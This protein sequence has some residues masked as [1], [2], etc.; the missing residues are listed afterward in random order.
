M[1]KKATEGDLPQPLVSLLD[2]IVDRELA[3]RLTEVMEAAGRCVLRLASI[4]LRELE[5]KDAD[6]GAADLTLWEKVAPAVGETVV[7]V[8]E[9]CA[10]IDAAFPPTRSRASLFGEE[11]SDQRAEYEAA[12]VFRAIS[13]LLKKELAD[14]SSLVRRPEMLSSPWG[15]LAELQRLRNGLRARVN[16]AVYLSA[17]AL[18]ACTRDEVVPGYAQEVIRALSFRGTETA[19]RRTAN[20]RIESA[21]DGAALAKALEGD[22]EA[23][24]SMPAWR[25]VKIETKRAMLRL[26]SQLRE[27]GAAEVEVVA[28]MVRPMLELLAQ[29]SFELSRTVLISHDRAA[30]NVALRRTEQAELHLN[31]ETGAAGWALEAAF[32]AANPLRGCNGPLD[33]LLRDAAARRVQELPSNELM[34]LAAELGASLTRLDL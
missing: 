10:V 14:I 7:A 19:L 15:L 17:G 6:D 8:N 2:A 26:R 22:F 24:A 13:P 12:A 18:G 27:A 32:D 31:L 20:N 28:A 34:E 29:T 9:L 30:R 16:D 3:S 21:K 23:M 33:E 1:K 5:P 4:N 25:H 11:G